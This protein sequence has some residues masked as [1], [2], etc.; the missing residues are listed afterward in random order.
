MQPQGFQNKKLPNSAFTA[1]TW[2][3][4]EEPYHGRLNDKSKWCPE[5]AG[6][7]SNYNY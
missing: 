3:D 2:N 1:D 5:K 6:N 7:V 4:G